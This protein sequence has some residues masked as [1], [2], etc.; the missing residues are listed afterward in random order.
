MR[1]A[2]PGGRRLRQQPSARS[3]FRSSA[4]HAAAKVPALLF[5]SERRG[6][7]ARRQAEWSGCVANASSQEAREAS[8][9]R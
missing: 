7:C 5:Y 4:E 9:L 2:R 1:S 3:V 6:R 8:E